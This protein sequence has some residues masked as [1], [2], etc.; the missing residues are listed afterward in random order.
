MKIRWQD[1]IPDTEIL[2]RANMPSMH[3]LLGKAQARW[4]GHVLRMNDQRIPKVLLY[5]ELAEGKRQVGRPKLRFKD[6]LK[7]TLKSL[8]VPVGTWEDIALDHGAA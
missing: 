3:T 8:E 7:A 2:A 1:H 6:N 5:G 4:A